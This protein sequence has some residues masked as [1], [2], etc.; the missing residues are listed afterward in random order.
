MGSALVLG[1]ARIVKVAESCLGKTIEY[2]C[3]RW[4]CEIL[5]TEGCRPEMTL[6]AGRLSM[7]VDACIWKVIDTTWYLSGVRLSS[8]KAD[9]M[10]LYWHLEGC[11]YGV[12]SRMQV[13]RVYRKLAIRV[14]LL[15][16]RLSRRCGISVKVGRK[17][18][19]VFRTRTSSPVSC[20]E[21]M[22]AVAVLRWTRQV[23]FLGRA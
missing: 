17:V 22:R 7:W 10:S 14:M 11:R 20:F 5:E 6:R 2:I 23:G 12:V 13:S 15:D 4:S 1:P 16:G 21:R 18:G 19:E 3:L 9:D 8:Q